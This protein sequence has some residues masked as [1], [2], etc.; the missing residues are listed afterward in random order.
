MWGKIPAASNKCRINRLK[1][2]PLKN[3]FYFINKNDFTLFNYILYAT[4]FLFSLLFFKNRSELQAKQI[5]NLENQF[6]IRKQM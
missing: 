6:R 4:F 1:K 5:T 3:E 2:N